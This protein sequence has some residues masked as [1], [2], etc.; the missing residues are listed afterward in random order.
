MVKNGG[1]IVDN[2]NSSTGSYI[3]FGEIK[4]G[5]SLHSPDGFKID[6]SNMVED[7]K[8]LRVSF[9]TTIPDGLRLNSLYIFFDENHKAIFSQ[10][11]VAFPGYNSAYL[12]I[13]KGTKH[14]RTAQRVRGIAKR[15]S[16][17]IKVSPIQIATIE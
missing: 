9:E 13:P 12:E 10:T 3:T 8:F 4:S 15:E 17:P 11:I 7:K 5:H 16:Q 6:L 14:L 1:V 2:A